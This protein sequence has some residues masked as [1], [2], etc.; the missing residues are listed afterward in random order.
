MTDR[1]LTSLVVWAFLA[2]LIVIGAAYQA[3]TWAQVCS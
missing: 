2:Q 3:Y 1:K